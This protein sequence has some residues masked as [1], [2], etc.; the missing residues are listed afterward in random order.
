MKQ[1]YLGDLKALEPHAVVR[2]QNSV[3]SATLPK[4]L[5]PMFVHVNAPARPGHVN[6]SLPIRE[7]YF[8]ANVCTAMSQNMVNLL[9]LNGSSLC[10]L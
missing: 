7:G 3:N 2:K 6:T 5:K 1:R 4:C 9:A 10:N 8:A